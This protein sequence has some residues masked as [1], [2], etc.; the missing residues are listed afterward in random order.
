MLSAC[1]ES[2]GM[3]KEHKISL[4]DAYAVETPDDSVQLYKEW[5]DTYD[6]EF[7]AATGYVAFQSAAKF[8]L[9]QTERPEGAVL[10]VGCGTGRDS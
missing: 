7:V 4:S 2:G 1:D 3:N 9:Q 5:A 6:E 8:F 10:D